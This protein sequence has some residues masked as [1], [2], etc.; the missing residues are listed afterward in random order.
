MIE[1]PVKTAGGK[2]EA[3]RIKPWIER[4]LRTLMDVEDVELVAM[5]VLSTIELPE[6]TISQLEG[7]LNRAHLEH[8]IH[9]LRSDAPGHM[10]S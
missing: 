10:S 2:Q 5:I 9:E 6:E 8:F 4:E 7:L 1:H 3:E